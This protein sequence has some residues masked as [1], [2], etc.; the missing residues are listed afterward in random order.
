MINKLLYFLVG[1]SVCGISAGQDSYE[2][3]DSIQ[4]NRIDSIRTQLLN[5]DQLSINNLNELTLELADSYFESGLYFTTDTL[6]DNFL[7]MNHSMVHVNMRFELLKYN[8]AADSLRNWLK[9]RDNAE[10]L[11]S[12]FEIQLSKSEQNKLIT[13]QIVYELGQ[14]YL[15]TERFSGFLSMSHRG[16]ELSETNSRPDL[17]LDLAAAH[18]YLNSSDPDSAMYYAESAIFL[19]QQL[20]DLPRL[21]FAHTQFAAILSKDQQNRKAFQHYMTAYELA[22][23]SGDFLMI[24][25]AS[26]YLAGF[27]EMTGRSEKAIPILREIMAQKNLRPNYGSPFNTPNSSIHQFER[28]ENAVSELVRERQRLFI[29]LILIVLFGVIITLIFRLR[30]KRREAQLLQQ[31]NRIQINPHFIFNSLNSLQRFIIEDDISASNKYLTR[32]S[33][34]IRSVLTNTQENYIPV[35]DEIKFLE[36]YLALEKLRFKDM[37]TY[38]VETKQG[39]DIYNMK[40]PTMIVQPFVE[41]SLWHGLVP[42]EVP[43][44]IEIIWNAADLSCLTCTIIDDGIGREKAKEI[45]GKSAKINSSVGTSIIKNRLDQLSKINKSNYQFKYDDLYDDGGQARGTKVVISIPLK[46]EKRKK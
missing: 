23:L 19:L 2:I 27:Y 37:F 10:R 34:L 36:D 17:L 4:T 21:S 25:I 5:I 3:P 9:M 16:L 40:M 11:I 12:Y 35:V 33:N 8:D 7:N 30:A 44:H 45:K 29:G 32:F 20:N 1:L 13:R 38:N 42:K 46:W 18:Y 6:V 22:R 41:N 43:G 15:N 39:V 24:D 14:V 28:A 26:N 31:I